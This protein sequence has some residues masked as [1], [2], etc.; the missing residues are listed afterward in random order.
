MR[1]SIFLTGN[2]FVDSDINE[3][4]QRILSRVLTAQAAPVLSSALKTKSSISPRK[5][6]WQL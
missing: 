1:M 5:I 3:N 6:L 2:H 4:R